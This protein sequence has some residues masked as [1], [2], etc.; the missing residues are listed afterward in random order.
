MAC[1]GIAPG[2]GQADCYLC[3]VVA[4]LPQPKERPATAPAPKR[5]KK[6]A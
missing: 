2:C 1:C 3:T 4:K 6:G 5:R